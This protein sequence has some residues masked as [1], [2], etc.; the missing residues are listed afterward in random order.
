MNV[1]TFW[2][3]RPPG[4]AR[5]S[6]DTG[7]QADY[8]VLEMVRQLPDGTWLEGRVARAGADGAARELS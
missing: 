1:L 2:P 4:L 6:D 7:A 8:I 3:V 5:V